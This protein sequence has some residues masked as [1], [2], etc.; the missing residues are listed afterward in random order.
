MSTQ[1]E[2]SPP[3][4]TSPAEAFLFE[5]RWKFLYPSAKHAGDFQLYAPDLMELRWSVYDSR[6]HITIAFGQTPE[7]ATDAAMHRVET[8]LKRGVS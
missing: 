5:Q 2:L 6:R 1:L 4:P 3:T 8:R 7:E